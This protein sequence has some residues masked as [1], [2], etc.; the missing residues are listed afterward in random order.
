MRRYPNEVDIY[1]LE[2]EI[3]V[4][5]AP[6][7]NR[8]MAMEYYVYGLDTNDG[9][10]AAAWH[11]PSKQTAEWV[12]QE[13]MRQMDCEHLT[14]Q[15][16]FGYIG[17]ASCTAIE[18]KQN[19]LRRFGF[20]KQEDFTF[21][22]SLTKKP[23]LL[24]KQYHGI[25]N[26][27]TD[28]MCHAGA[29]LEE[30][31][32]PAN[33]DAPN[34]VAGIPSVALATPIIAARIKKHKES[35][36]KTTFKKCLENGQ[37]VNT[38]DEMILKGIDPVVREA[39]RKDMEEA[40]APVVEKLNKLHDRFDRTILMEFASEEQDSISEDLPD[41][42]K[43]GFWESPAKF[44]TRT[45]YKEST[46]KKHRE[47]GETV[48]VDELSVNSGEYHQFVN[49][50][51]ENTERS[52]FSDTCVV[53]GFGEYRNPESPTPGQETAENCVNS[54]IPENSD[55]NLAVETVAVD[56]LPVNV[57][58]YHQ[59]V[60][61]ADTVEIGEHGESFHEY[62]RGYG[63]NNVALYDHHERMRRSQ[64]SRYR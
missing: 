16:Q 3:I 38:P 53:E 46:L 63:S 4:A 31:T 10:I 56:E 49:G 20:F 64:S 47:E 2:E 50:N 27:L 51:I 34:M 44:A 59:I 25:A 26:D 40:I 33:N 18:F 32:S 39:S 54:G 22:V 30:L 48:D 1:D 6:Y 41:F 43:E 36:E 17:I 7:L 35:A 11:C 62:D 19:G 55:T 12:Y 13:T 58:E 52:N 60:N 45:K 28:F 42:D 8:D 24:A 21:A 23:V 29:L 15:F 5:V 61:T 14:G 57:G 37:I 9:R